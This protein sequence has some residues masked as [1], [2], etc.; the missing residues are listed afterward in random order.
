MEMYSCKKDIRPDTDERLVIWPDQDALCNYEMGKAFFADS[1]T[2]E[3][4]TVANC[5]HMFHSEEAMILD[6]VAP[7]V[8]KHFTD[9]TN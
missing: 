2:T 3:F 9:N 1:K 4:V 6:Q 8:R 7:I 5:G